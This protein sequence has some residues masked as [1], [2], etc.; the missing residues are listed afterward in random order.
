[1]EMSKAIDVRVPL[2]FDQLNSILLEIAESP[3]R[4]TPPLLVKERKSPGWEAHVATDLARQA[5][6]AIISNCVMTIWSET[7]AC[8]QALEPAF[9]LYPKSVRKFVEETRLSF[10]S[11][12]SLLYHMCNEPYEGTETQKDI[13]RLRR[14]PHPLIAKT[15]AMLCVRTI[16]S[17][18]RR[19]LW[20]VLP[21]RH[22]PKFRF[23]IDIT[24]STCGRLR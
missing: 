10:H 23:S 9:P 14:E 24:V 6:A 13:A 3:L 2:R 5:S 4:F 18:S 11:Y 19:R 1:M 7:V 12:V 16:S 15:I 17:M 21:R 22:V 20:W 8:L